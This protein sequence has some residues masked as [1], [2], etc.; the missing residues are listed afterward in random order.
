MKS[1]LV[2]N[3]FVTPS[4]NTNSTLVVTFKK[5]LYKLSIQTGEAGAMNM[6]YEYGSTPSFDFT[7]SEGWKIHTIFFND[8][9]VTNSMDNGFYTAPPITG[10]STLK[11]VFVSIATDAAA[12]SDN[13][14]KVYTSQSEIIVEGVLEGETV[15]LFT[16]NGT[17]LQSVRSQSERIVLSVPSG[18]VYLVKTATRIFKVIL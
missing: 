5:S 8:D 1:K 16:I 3:A 10:N 15:K 13:K 9:D 12:L 17:Q 4:L 7:P 6:L 2:N 14:L 11:V 18:S